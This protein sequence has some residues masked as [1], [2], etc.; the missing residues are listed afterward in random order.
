MAQYELFLKNKFVLEQ[1]K[2]ESSASF[3]EKLVA[4]IVDNLRVSVKNVYF[5]FEDSH[6]VRVNIGEGQTRMEQ[7]KFSIG[8]TLREFSIFT[9]DKNYQSVQNRERDNK[10]LKKNIGDE[11]R[12]TFKTVKLDGFSVFCNWKDVDSRID[13]EKLV[14]QSQQKDT[15][16]IQEVLDAEYEGKNANSYFLHDLNIVLNLQL[17]NDV[18]NPLAPA[19]LAYPQY[20]AHMTIGSL[21]QDAELLVPAKISLF[22]PQVLRFLKTVE[23]IGFFNEFRD[24]VEAEF[25]KRKL[26]P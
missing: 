2:R 11:E 4:R 1:S 26:S 20:K 15:S 12:L 16:Y 25:L 6:N 8:L 13:L 22:Q 5:R 10:R 9:T 17:N 18:K 24:G 7:E 23:L 21:G 3:S 19:T 14:Q